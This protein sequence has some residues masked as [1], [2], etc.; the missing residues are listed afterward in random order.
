MKTVYRYRTLIIIGLIL[1]VFIILGLIYNH[2]EHRMNIL[3]SNPLSEGWKDHATNTF[4]DLPYDFDL[5][6]NET[7]GFSLIL[8]EDFK[9]PQYLLIRGSLQDV[10]VAIGGNIIY[11]HD[12]REEDS[13]IPYAGLWHYI[14][15]PADSDGLELTV[16]LHTPYEAMSGKVNEIYYGSYNDLNAHIFINYGQGFVIGLIT[17]FIGLAITLISL[18]VDKIKDND[19]VYLGLFAIILSLWMLSE[20]RT[21]QILLDSQYILGALS[22][23]A[24]ALL[25]IPMAVYLKRILLKEYTKIY[26]IIIVYSFILFISIVLLQ[27]FGIFGFFQSVFITQISLVIEVIVTFILLL[28]HL[29]KHPKHQSTKTF[30]TYFGIFAFI[31]FMEFASF[32]LEDFDLI[33]VFVQGVVVI[34]MIVLFSRYIM[35]LNK[36]YHIRV[37]RETLEKMA[38]IDRLTGSKNRHAF[39]ED[40]DL[41]FSHQQSKRQLKLV[42]FDFN[43]LK[44]INDNYGHDIGDQMIVDGYQMIEKTFGE[45]GK[46]YRIG[47]DEFSCIFVGVTNKL[48]QQQSTQFND[49]IDQYNNEKPYKFSVSY[50][51]AA[52]QADKDMKPKD[53]VKRADQ[54]MYKDKEKYRTKN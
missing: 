49:L 23:Y 2:G 45:L 39:E 25:P 47:G 42:Y 22:Y 50:G 27:Q 7:H 1:T 6:P 32:V 53:L 36:N 5:E 51:I 43:D 31:G 46:C 48:Y 26:H 34:F 15:V 35:I 54:K 40:L 8:P 16:F 11:S 52:Y 30:I 29:K 38:Y 37:E 18:F 20:S 12:L 41:I 9:H 21:L 14:P 17:F 19:V 13:S 44:T 4:F 28:I 3:D 33:S 10:V 24:L